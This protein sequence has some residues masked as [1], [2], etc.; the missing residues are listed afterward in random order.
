MLKKIASLATLLILFAWFNP[1]SAARPNYAPE[2]PENDGIYD[3]PGQPNMK[4]K[5]FVHKTKDAKPSPAPNLTPIGCTDP[6]ENNATVSAAGW[7]LPTTYAYNL[8]PASVPAYVFGISAITQ[9]SFNEWSS[10]TSGSVAIFR[11]DDTKITRAAYDGRNIITW[12]KAN[13]SALAVT[14]IWYNTTTGDIREL[15]TVMNNKF[16]WTSAA[17]YANSYD[18]QNILTHELGHWFGLNDHYTP[19]YLDNTMYGYGSKGESKKTTLTDGDIAGINAI[20]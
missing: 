14:Y 17:C 3:V 4:V 2:L 5:I 6:N 20:Y 13:A 1:A 19:D 16:F 10:E 9:D 12:G 18:A 8:N 15:D 11:G 7:H